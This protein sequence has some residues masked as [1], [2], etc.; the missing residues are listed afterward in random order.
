MSKKNRFDLEQ[1]I[2]DCW[3]VTED[4]SMVTKHFIDSPQWKGMSAELADAIMNKYFAIE[5][6]YEL[7]FQKLFDTFVDC[8][9]D[10]NSYIE[11]D[12]GEHILEH[13]FSETELRFITDDEE[14]DSAP[15]DVE[16]SRPWD[17]E[18][19]RP[20]DVEDSAPWDVEDS[21]PWDVEDSGKQLELGLRL[22]DVTP[23]EWDEVTSK[24]HK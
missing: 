17:V 9:P 2:M 6:L 19:S 3:K 8:I 22:N 5:E 1:E 24:Y 4:I 12:S 16:D 14:E 15:W 18:D 21:A 23:A 7:R 20:W 13:L 11:D 10:L